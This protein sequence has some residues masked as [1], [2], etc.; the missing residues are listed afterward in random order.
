MNKK[1]DL[2]EINALSKK[3][4]T[5]KEVVV[6]DLN[7]VSACIDQLSSMES[8]Q[9][10]TANSAKQYFSYS[11]QTIIASFQ[12][13][14]I[15]IHENLKD[16]IDTF[17]TNVDTSESARLLSHYLE[18]LKKILMKILLHWKKSQMK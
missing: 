12:H 14:F 9:G 3:V 17:Q 6:S 7:T 15:N 13:I 18:E 5:A 11:H 2:I 10:E 16:H 4:A 1:V 8:F